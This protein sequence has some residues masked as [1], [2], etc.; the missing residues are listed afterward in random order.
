M[1]SNK[2]PNLG[3]DIWQPEDFFKRAEVNNNFTKIDAKSKENSDRIGDLSKKSYE[4]N[5]KGTSPF[6]G[7]D[8]PMFSIID[9]D[10][11]TRFLDISK[12][13]LDARGIKVSLAAITNRVGTSG[14]L[15]KEQLL[16]LQKEN[17]EIVSHTTNHANIYNS[18]TSTDAEIEASLR[19]SQNWLIENGFNGYDTV[20]YPYGAVNARAK[21]L[22]AKYYK[23][24]V[25][26]SGDDI[27]TFPFDNLQIP[28]KGIRA[29]EDFTTVLKPIIDSCIANKGWLIFLTH[30]GDT[31]EINTNNLTQALDYVLSKGGV[32]LPFGEAYKYKGNAL[33]I[34]D[35]TS[36]NKLFMSNNGNLT[37]L[38]SLPNLVPGSL[39][40][41]ANAID[42]ARSTYQDGKVTV[43]RVATGASGAINEGGVLITSSTDQY[44][45]YQTFITQTRMFTR[46]W[47]TSTNT[48]K[49][50]VE[51]VTTDKLTQ[52]VNKT[53]VTGTNTK[54]MDDPLTAYTQWKETIVMI[55]ADKDTFKG[56][57]GVMKVTRLDQYYSY[58][59]FKPSQEN[60]IYVRKWN[61]GT[62][63]WGSWGV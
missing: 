38:D 29:N 56:Q 46:R 47:D 20:V 39:L 13:L 45:T 4:E 37:G 25:R 26:S 19:D 14:Y 32:F 5:K 33:S 54:T 49:A 63:S 22:V 62:S 3:L 60:V 10:I 40:T 24:G 44:Y 34:G 35:F 15:T 36:S 61:V 50:W 17:H 57:G 23:N 43:S 52:D 7:N 30:S 28:R 53:L 12:P 48:W 31:N 6:Y 9:D 41:T 2:T 27:K 16:Q 8:I 18:D 59:T 55:A 42:N 11:T 58:A 51:Y 21:K 1:A